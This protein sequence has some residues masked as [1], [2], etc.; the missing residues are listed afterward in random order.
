M[1]TRTFDIG[2]NPPL[3]VWTVVRGDTASFKVYV[4]DDQREALDLSAWNIRMDI[5]RNGTDVATIF[6]APDAD[7]AIGEFTV[8]ITAAESEILE[9]DD[10]FDNQLS[11]PQ[12]QLVWTV[13][14]GKMNIIE[15]ITDP[16]VEAP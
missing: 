4:T 15:D 7:D 2:N 5:E 16:F 10:V 1:T 3:I 9:K 13:A 14:Q 6:P 11:L 12:D 8:F